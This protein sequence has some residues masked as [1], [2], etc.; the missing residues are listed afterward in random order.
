MASPGSR[1]LA[2]FLVMKND[3]LADSL[4]AGD[5][6]PRGRPGILSLYSCLQWRVEAYDA[7]G[8]GVS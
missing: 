1:M 7:A 3:T 5:H 4:K 2:H 6:I 8:S